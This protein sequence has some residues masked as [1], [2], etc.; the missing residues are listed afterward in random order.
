MPRATVGHSEFHLMTIPGR[1]GH[2][3]VPGQFV[4][5]NRVVQQIQNRLPKPRRR[6][7]RVPPVVAHQVAS[8]IGNVLGAFPPALCELRRTGGEEIE[9]I[10]DLEVA[11]GAGQ[12]FIPGFGEAAVERTSGWR[13]SNRK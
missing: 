1:Q 8:G 10:E 9:R 3:D 4:V 2:L 11:G 13:R 7:V 6:Q 5:A 12:Q